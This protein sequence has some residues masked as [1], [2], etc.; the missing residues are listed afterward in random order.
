MAFCASSKSSFFY[1]AC[2][3]TGVVLYHNII[4]DFNFGVKGGSGG[5]CSKKEL[6]DGLL[7]M[8][9]LIDQC[10]VFDS[11]EVINSDGGCFC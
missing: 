10:S 1:E 5:F 4:K 7:D 8:A 9:L 3:A 11:S 2:N 6:L